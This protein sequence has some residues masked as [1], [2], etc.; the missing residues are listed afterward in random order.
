MSQQQAFQ[1]VKFKQDSATKTILID[2]PSPYY[3][4][5]NRFNFK[6]QSGKDVLYGADV[7][8]APY[9]QQPIQLNQFSQIQQHVHY[10]VINDLGGYVEF[11]AD[12]R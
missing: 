7:M 2:N 6:N 12:V 8:V 11:K 3:I 10:E 4:T 9:S 5:F 1:A